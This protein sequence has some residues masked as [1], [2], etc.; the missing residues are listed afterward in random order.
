[1][2]EWPGQDCKVQCKLN[3]MYAVGWGGEA[4]Q[5][6]TFPSNLENKCDPETMLAGDKDSGTKQLL[7]LFYFCS[8]YFSYDAFNHKYQKI[9]LI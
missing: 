5:R 4:M 1:M 6:P 7:L 8:Q 9:H 3:Y 2:N